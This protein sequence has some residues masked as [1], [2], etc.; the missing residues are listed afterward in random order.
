MW[1]LG[2]KVSEGTCHRAAVLAGGL[3]QVVRKPESPW[4]GREEA[5]RT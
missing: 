1:H 2:K 5:S 3:R 4:L